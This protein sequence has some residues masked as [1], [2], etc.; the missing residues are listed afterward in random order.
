MSEVTL[1]LDF[2]LQGAHNDARV[3]R[4]GTPT[5]P[6]SISSEEGTTRNKGL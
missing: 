1:Y 4:G 6:L 5:K 2:S 3:H